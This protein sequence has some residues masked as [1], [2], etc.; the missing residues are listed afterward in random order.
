M[1][2]LKLIPDGTAEVPAEAH[3]DS[4]MKSY[5]EGATNIL[6]GSPAPI[7]GWRDITRH[8]PGH[9]RH[10]ALRVPGEPPDYPVDSLSNIANAIVGNIS[11]LKEHPDGWQTVEER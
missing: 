3:E 6:D 10:V 5:L 9:H 1:I 8:I 11:G 2:E 4:I 7:D